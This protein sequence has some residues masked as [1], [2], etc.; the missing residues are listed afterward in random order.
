MAWRTRGGSRA[1]DGTC[2]GRPRGGR[3]SASVG[4]GRGVIRHA[5]TVLRRAAG[6]R[7]RRFTLTPARSEHELQNAHPACSHWG[8]WPPPAD[9]CAAGIAAAVPAS[10]KSRR[11]FADG[12][13]LH[14]AG[15]AVGGTTKNARRSSALAGE[16]AG[17]SVARDRRRRRAEP[18]VLHDQPLQK[19][20]M[21]AAQ[22]PMSTEQA[23][24][25]PS[26]TR[27]ASSERR[28]TA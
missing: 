2:R 10:V 15:S 20:K 19:T 21:T 4:A 5:N 13:G 26:C 22:P 27:V 6:R 14:G 24:R 8:P 23:A 3:R 17:Q 1:A 12:R 11:A 28:F 9:L 25:S 7:Y 18:G 16:R